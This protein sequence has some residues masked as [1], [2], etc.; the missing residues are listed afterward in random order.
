MGTLAVEAQSWR[1]TEAHAQETKDRF[2]EYVDRD[3][4]LRVHRDYIEK[5]ALGMGE[6]CFHWLWKLIVDEMPTAFS[7]LEVGVYKGQVLSLV[8]LLANRTGRDAGVV[9]VTMLSDFAGDTDEFPR[10][11]DEDYGKYIR[12]LH[13]M[14]SLEQPHL[15]VGDST[16][17]GV[18]QAVQELGP[19]DIIY[20]DGCHEYDYVA[21]DLLFYPT[22]VKPGGL[23][24]VDDAS[25]DLKQPWGFFQGIAPVSRAVRTVIETDLQ[26]EHLL[27]VVH[28]RVWRK[29]ERHKHPGDYPRYQQA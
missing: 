10:Y 17:P 5:H 27:A 7:F 14:L 9:G 23:L 25:C 6:R 3:L 13:E 8:K 24:V 20:I 26:W 12:E 2:T 11:P 28:N 4:Q 1:D 21:S 16:D 29:H 15:V 22:L 18:Q 19:F